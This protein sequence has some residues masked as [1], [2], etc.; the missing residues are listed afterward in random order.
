MR[1]LHEVDV[2][3]RQCDVLREAAPSVEAGLPLVRT[4]LVVA[5]LADKAPAAGADKGDSHAI[6]DAPA[7]DL[8]AD[9][10]NGAG[11][12]VAGDVGEDRDVVVSVPGMPVATAQPSRLDLEH[13]AVGRRHRVSHL[14][15]APR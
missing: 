9:R 11:E 5:R 1:Q 3:G 7:R 2:R 14:V 8:G 10:R 13:H 15:R 4:D 6:A 12:L